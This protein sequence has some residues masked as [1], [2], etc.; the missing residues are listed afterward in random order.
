[1]AQVFIGIG[2]NLQREYSLCRGMALLEQLF[3]P[4]RR[5]A[6]YQS[7]AVGFNGPDF[8]N[9]VAYF[10]TSL[11]LVTIARVLRDIEYQCGRPKAAKKC[12]SRM[13]DIDLLLYDSI[14]CDAPCRLP[15]PEIAVNAFV[16]RPLAELAGER[17]H[18][19]TSCSLAQMW[20]QLKPT[21]IPLTRIDDSFLNHTSNDYV[22]HACDYPLP[23]SGTY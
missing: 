12:S 17:V 20:R 21:A 22:H 2:S 11:P 6:I 14:V 3:G 16:L 5:S 15:R 1:M 9:L 19:L 4:L 10:E 8:Y 23:D 18:P 7:E 13:L